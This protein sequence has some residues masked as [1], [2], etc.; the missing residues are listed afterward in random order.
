MFLILCH[1]VLL[2]NV[3]LNHSN[4]N[5][6]FTLKNNEQYLVIFIQNQIINIICR[7][8]WTGLP[9]E[10]GIRH[11][12]FSVKDFC[13][14]DG[15]FKEKV[16]RIYAFVLQGRKP[17]KLPRTSTRQIGQIM[18]SNAISTSLY[19]IMY[20][21]GQSTLVSSTGIE[22]RTLTSKGLLTELESAR[23]HNY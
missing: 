7:C 20:F 15:L 1:D 11:F 6:Y 18:V 21:N 13:L 8:R 17:V 5:H 22:S 9:T 23:N 10:V 12:I 14:A 19:L 16:G 2:F 4:Q 3:F